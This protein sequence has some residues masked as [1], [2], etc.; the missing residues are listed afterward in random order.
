MPANLRLATASVNTGLDALLARADGGFL[1]I[2]DGDQPADANTAISSQ[3]LLATLRFSSPA[4]SA[5]TNGT[6]AAH[7]I[8][9]DPAI[10][11][12]GTASW[13]RLLAANGTSV[14]CDLSVATVDANIVFPS[15]N[16]QAGG[17]CAV[18]SLTL[19]LPAHG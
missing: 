4:F 6:A 12:T 2:Y 3:Q 13:A 11:A 9:S 15:V 19:R 14:V 17:E 5:A 18:S 16:F 1:K 10:A 7:A 8:T